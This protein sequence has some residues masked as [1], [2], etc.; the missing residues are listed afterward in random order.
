MASFSIRSAKRKKDTT[1]LPQELIVR[2]LEEAPKNDPKEEKDVAFQSLSFDISELLDIIEAKGVETSRLVQLEWIWMPALEHSKRGP[3]A[4]QEALNSDP[5]LFIDILKL[6]YRGKNEKHR[7]QS[8]QE[9]ARA[10]QASSP[11]NS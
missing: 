7:E 9:Q 6:V 5:K 8:D 3:K 1:A 10:V 11:D 2:L 4:L